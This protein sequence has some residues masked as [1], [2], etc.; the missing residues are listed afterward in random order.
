MC[1]IPKNVAPFGA[2]VHAKAR[3]R[4][5][6][7]RKG[8]FFARALGPRL[9]SRS[10]AKAIRGHRLCPGGPEDQVELKPVCKMDI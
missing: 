3:S 4:E 7:M 5:V 6:P 1:Y 10:Q 9:W 8:L 2:N